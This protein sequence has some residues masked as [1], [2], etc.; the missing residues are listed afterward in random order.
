MPKT[1]GGAMPYG[2]KSSKSGQGAGGSKLGPKYSN[3]STVK[4]PK[5]PKAK[6][7]TRSDYKKPK[8]AG[9]SEA[10]STRTA[11]GPG[12]A[13]KTSTSSGYKAPKPAGSKSVSSHAG[14]TTGR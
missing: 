11:Y 6:T 14:K 12:G 1:A 7:T 13:G 2:K 10:G 3:P 5:N 8:P 9:S 4:T